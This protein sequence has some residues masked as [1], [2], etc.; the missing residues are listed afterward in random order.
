M[1][2]S[3]P[4][5]L[6]ILHPAPVYLLFHAGPFVIQGE[7]RRRWLQIEKSMCAG[8]KPGRLGIGIV[9]AVLHFP[10]VLFCFSEAFAA[11]VVEEKK[12]TIWF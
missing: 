2:A 3:L 5:W 8:G 7:V 12:K 10:G 1:D 6:L 9:N 4:G 11:F